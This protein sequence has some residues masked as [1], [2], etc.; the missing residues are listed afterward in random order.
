MLFTAALLALITITLFTF[1]GHLY[2]LECPAAFDLSQE[3]GFLLIAATL[4]NA[5]TSSN[6]R[7]K[8]A[9]LRY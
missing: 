7:C 6:D 9:T 1:C 8:S 2:I 4:P 3:S 5:N